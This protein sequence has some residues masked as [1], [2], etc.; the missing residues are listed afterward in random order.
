M[1]R[2]RPFAVLCAV[3]LGQLSFAQGLPEMNKKIIE[4]GEKRNQAPLHI[5]HLTKKIGP[6]LLGSPQFEKACNWTLKKFRDWGLKNVHFE[7]FMDVPFGFERGKQQMGR[8]LSPV[9]RDFQFST[10]AWSVG[11]KG[12][13]KG[14]AIEEPKDEEALA[15]AKDSLS[16]AWILAGGD[17]LGIRSRPDDSKLEFRKKIETCGIAGWVYA[18]ANEYVTTNGNMRIETLEALPKIPRITVRAS[19]MAAIREAL[20]AGKKPELEFDIDNRFLKK[21]VTVNNVVA[22]IP[23]TEK[24]DEVVI[25]GAH[26]DSWNGP[27]SEGACDNGTGVTAVLEA[28]R[29]LGKYNVKP[30]RTIRFILF[31]GEEEGLLGSSAYVKAHEKELDKISA[32]FV[33]DSGTN[34]DS[35]LMCSENA[36]KLLI[37]ATDPLKDTDKAFEFKIATYQPSGTGAGRRRGGGG[38]SDHAPFQAAGVPAFFMRKTGDANYMEIWHTQNDN[39]AHVNLKNVSRSGLVFAVLGY[40]LACADGLVSRE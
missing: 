6:R 22:D 33:D 2:T 21:N 13:V 39:L 17:G 26:L 25:I 8:M 4:E 14:I 7:P 32:V 35:G 16:G 12:A 5:K 1:K 34:Y 31:G 18:S 11:T 27:G 10:A 28:A 19:D 23:G 9:K 29:I 37:P 38:G 3:V 24:P 20:A 36:G 40:N 30:K 15:K